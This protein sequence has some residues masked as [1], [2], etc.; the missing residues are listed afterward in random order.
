ME[1]LY[2]HHISRRVTWLVHLPAS[3]NGRYNWMEEKTGYFLRLKEKN[4]ILNSKQ[5]WNANL[6]QKVLELRPPHGGVSMDEIWAELRLMCFTPPTCKS[7][8]YFDKCFEILSFLTTDC[9]ENTACGEGQAACGL[10]WLA[11][12]SL[13]IWRPIKIRKRH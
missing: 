7:K 3:E 9:H 12:E 11:M 2:S 8:L 5:Q 4:I 13:T 6:S 1:T 10:S